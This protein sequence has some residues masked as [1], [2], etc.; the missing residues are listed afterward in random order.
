MDTFVLLSGTDITECEF[1]GCGQITAN[2]AK[3][4]DSKVSGYEGAT[5][6]SAVLWNANTNP[7]GLLDGMTFTRGTANTHA[8]EF[9]TNSPTSL[10]LSGI[11]FTGYNTSNGQVDSALH[12]LRTTGNV[13]ITVTGGTTPTYKSEG[14]NVS[15]TSAVLVTLT[16][17]KVNTEVRVFNANT[18]TELSGTGAEN[19][20]D[21]DHSFSVSSGTPVDISILSFGYQN[22]RILNYS[23]TANASIP[24][25]QVLDRQYL[26]P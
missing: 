10:T 25:S 15:V 1:R 24:V 19:I 11:T 13:D 12:I 23:T 7:S 18:T 6:T 26:N 20:D 2:G 5:N 9:G 3:L 14:A 21:G 8:I 22:L 17:L 16:G 4:V